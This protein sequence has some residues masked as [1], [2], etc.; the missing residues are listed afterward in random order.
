[1][2]GGRDFISVSKAT[3]P[4]ELLQGVNAKEETR[5]SELGETP[6]DTKNEGEVGEIEVGLLFHFL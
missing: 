1:M 2:G 5:A 6:R 4:G 3:G